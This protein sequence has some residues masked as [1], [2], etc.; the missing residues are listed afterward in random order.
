MIEIY[1][2]IQKTGKRRWEEP[3]A[4]CHHCFHCFK[5]TTCAKHT[6][7]IGL[8]IRINIFE[9]RTKRFQLILQLKSAQIYKI[10][11]TS[12]S[13]AK[14]MLYV[15]QSLKSKTILKRRKTRCAHL[16]CSLVY[17]DHR[18]CHCLRKK[19]MSSVLQNNYRLN[20]WTTSYN[21]KKK[22][23]YKWPYCKM[24]LAE[25]MKSYPRRQGEFH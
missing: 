9:A 5:G 10:W 14:C 22:L 12:R 1:L 25:T 6:S 24:Q 7:V 2:Y 23:N 3:V 20:N 18:K 11:G 4:F 13:S 8:P 17:I 15:I 19:L 16:I 21:G